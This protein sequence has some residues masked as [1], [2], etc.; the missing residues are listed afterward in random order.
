[1]QYS[2]QPNLCLENCTNTLTVVDINEM[3]KQLL[4]FFSLNNN[5]KKSNTI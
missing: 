2:V 1:M 5:I 3:L 4:D